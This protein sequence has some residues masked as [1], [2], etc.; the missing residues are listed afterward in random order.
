[1]RESKTSR[2]HHVHR[3]IK[4]VRP[5]F[6]VFMQKKLWYL[7]M[8]YNQ[9]IVMLPPSFLKKA[10]HK[11]KSAIKSNYKHRN[12]LEFNK[13]AKT[14]RHKSHICSKASPESG[15][16]HLKLNHNASQLYPRKNTST[17]LLPSFK[18]LVMPQLDLCVK[19]YKLIACVVSAKR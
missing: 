9:K 19:M 15:A 2:D 17:R 4:S 8:G 3:L 13:E 18:Y 14:M 5:V 16:Y 12:C 6:F 10:N 11:S 1:M 7:L